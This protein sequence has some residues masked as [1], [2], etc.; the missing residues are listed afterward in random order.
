MALYSLFARGKKQPASK[1]GRPSALKVRALAA[2]DLPAPVEIALSRRTR[3][4]SMRID[5]QQDLVRVT[6][7][8]SMSDAE[9]LRFLRRHKDWLAKRLAARP[10]KLTLRDGAVVPILGIDHTIRH[11]PEHRGATAIVQGP[12]GPE[13]HVGGS[14]EFTVRRVV[15]FLKAR[16]RAWL[17]AE[18]RVIALKIARPVAAVTVRDTRSRWG[19]CSVDGRLSFCWRLLLAPESVARYVVAH[20]V[21]HLRHL[22]HSDRFWKLC[23]DLVGDIDAPRAWLREQGPRLHRYG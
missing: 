9:I 1:T 10:Q 12:D 5:P 16:A 19:S 3:R 18:A 22:D 13:I 2:A 4:L 15:D 8:L 21:A 20:E 7:P 6:G 17:G 23:A 11:R 14:P